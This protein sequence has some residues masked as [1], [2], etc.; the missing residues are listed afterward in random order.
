MAIGERLAARE[1]GA[2]E[3]GREFEIIGRP[4]LY[5]SGRRHVVP[6]E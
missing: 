6:L 4:H 3:I 1:M 5:G 2:R